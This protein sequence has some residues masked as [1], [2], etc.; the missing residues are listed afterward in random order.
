M[1]NVNKKHSLKIIVGFYKKYIFLYICFLV[2]LLIK[3]IIS[4]FSTMLI[5]KIITNI[6][7]LN[8]E[9]V[10]KLATTNLIILSVYHFLSYI[11][12]Y[13]Y[14]NLENRVRYD[15]Q[16]KVIESVLNMKMQYYDNTGSG[17]ILTR[18]I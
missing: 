4:F 2:I 5:A 8:F 1:V 18:L 11:N 13:F 14:K 3:A 17:V 9:I 12:I 10:I 6:M 16:Q 15:I 7:S